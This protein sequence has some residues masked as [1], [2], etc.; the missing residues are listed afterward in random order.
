MKNVKIVS[1][2]DIGL[3]DKLAIVQ[4]YIKL[5]NQA[6]TTKATGLHVE[7]NDVVYCVS[8]TTSNTLHNFKIWNV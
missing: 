6:C 1:V 8:H 2:S 4:E 5:H 7:Y 3:I